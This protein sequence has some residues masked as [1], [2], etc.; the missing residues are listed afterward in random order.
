MSLLLEEKRLEGVESGRAHPFYAMA[1]AIEKHKPQLICISSTANM[2]LSR[3]RASTFNF[4]RR[5]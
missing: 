2:A 1:D 5:P 4:E 3:T